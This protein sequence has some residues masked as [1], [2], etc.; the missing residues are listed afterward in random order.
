MTEGQQ[1]WVQLLAENL[2]IKRIIIETEDERYDSEKYINKPSGRPIQRKEKK[3]SP[4]DL[5]GSKAGSK[6]EAKVNSE[7]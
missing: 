2:G 3:N 4:S 6:A 7:I 5:A 1:E